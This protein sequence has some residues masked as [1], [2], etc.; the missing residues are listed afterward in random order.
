MAMDGQTWLFSGRSGMR[1]SEPGGVSGSMLAGP[2]SPCG[3][4]WLLCVA[5]SEKGDALGTPAAATEC[6]QSACLR[7]RASWACKACRH[8][9]I[10]SF[11]LSHQTALKETQGPWLARRSLASVR[12]QSKHGELFCCRLCIYSA[13]HYSVMEL[14]DAAVYTQSLSRPHLFAGHAAD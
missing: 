11:S 8:L 4:L 2:A 14:A 1:R 10:S 13:L 9:D 12:E 3:A 7:P 6:Y 5:V